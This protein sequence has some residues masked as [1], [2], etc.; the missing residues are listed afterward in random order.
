M[1]SISSCSTHSSKQQQHFSDVRCL[2]QQWGPGTAGT[3]KPPSSWQSRNTQQ[4]QQQ[5]QRIGPVWLITSAWTRFKQ[6]QQQQQQLCR[7]LSS[8]ACKQKH[9]Q[10]LSQLTE[11]GVSLQLQQQLLQHH[12]QHQEQGNAAWVLQL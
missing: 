8:V 2:Q 10:Q 1:R 11:L 9:Q 12:E 3:Q 4:Q 7:V 5:Q 6:Q